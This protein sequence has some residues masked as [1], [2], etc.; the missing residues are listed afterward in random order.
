MTSTRKEGGVKEESLE[1]LRVQDRDGAEMRQFTMACE[2]ISAFIHMVGQ[3]QP[4]I[5]ATMRRVKLHHKIFD[6][7]M[8][9]IDFEIEQM[10]GRST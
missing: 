3:R 2:A 5:E 10:K 4:T 1:P 9:Q 8:E 6:L 7:C